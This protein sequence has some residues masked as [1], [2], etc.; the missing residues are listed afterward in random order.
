MIEIVFVLAAE[1][2]I[3]AAYEFHENCQSG[4]GELLLGSLNAALA[5]LSIYP[6]I[7]PRV[8]NS[9]RRLLV[10]GFPYGI[11][12]VIEGKRLIVVGVLDL[13]RDP[14]AIHQCLE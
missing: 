11:F 12:Y 10:T 3:Q 8:H 6:E 14:K 9:Y 4:R 5:Q 1:I 13:R 7:G 2:D